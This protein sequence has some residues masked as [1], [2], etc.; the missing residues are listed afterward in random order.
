[1]RVLIFLIGLLLCESYAADKTPEFVTE[2]VP[3]WVE[4]VKEEEL[5]NITDQESASGVYY[6]LVDSQIK[7]ET[8]KIEY[9]THI[10]KKVIN[11]NGI[12][13][14]ALLEIE[15]DPLCE[16]ISLHHV[17]VKRGKDVINHL[18]DAKIKVLQR[19]REL[20]RKNYS[21]RKSISIILDDIRVG[22]IISY[23]FTLK[24]TNINDNKSFYIKVYLSNSVPIRS[25]SKR[26][27]WPQSLPPLAI[28]NHSTDF[29]VNIKKQGKYI[30]Y[31]WQKKDVPVY[32]DEPYTPVWHDVE[33]WIEISTNLN[34]HDI[35]LALSEHYKV[36]DLP[37][38]IKKHVDRIIS[39]EKNLGKR[40]IT[41]MHFIQDEIRYM[42]MSDRIDGYKPLNAEL[43]YE[44]R[45]GDCKDKTYLALTMLKALGIEVHP[46]VVHTT[47]GKLLDSRLANPAIFNHIIVVAI[48][49][50]KKYWIDPTCSFQGGT[51]KNY[52]QPDYGYAL[53]LD[54]RSKNLVKMPSLELAEPSIEFYEKFDLS[55]GP[56]NPNYLSIKTVYK[57]MHADSQREYFHI[58]PKK[59]MNEF[60]LQYLQ[61]NYPSIRQKS[62]VI[63]LDDREKNV[64]IVAEDYEIPD[65]WKR[66]EA[67]KLWIMY[68]YVDEFITYLNNKNIFADRKTPVSNIFPRYITKKIEM[69][70]HDK[71]DF[72]TESIAVT[73][74][75]FEF[76]KETQLQDL[77]YSI[78]YVY[79]SLSDQVEHK[80]IASYI[81]NTD[82]AYALLK[83]N[84]CQFDPSPP[85]KITEKK[86]SL[87]WPIFLLLV[88]ALIF[89][90]FLAKKIYISKPKVLLEKDESSKLYGIEGWPLL[91]GF[92]IIIN[93]IVYF[94]VFYST[95]SMVLSHDTWIRLSTSSA[96][97]SFLL[98]LIFEETFV[99]LGLVALWGLTAILFLKKKHL[100]PHV[101]VFALFGD[102]LF[103]ISD[104]VLSYFFLSSVSTKTNITTSIILG[105]IVLIWSVYMAKS[106][107]IRVTFGQNFSFNF[108][109][110]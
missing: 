8:Y 83:S 58:T 70:L 3:S 64:V 60:Y 28:K 88:I 26:I 41:V 18:K 43:T 74:P 29:Q 72:K 47:F 42:G 33:P 102:F 63:I 30:E 68:T 97:K 23:S 6:Q 110:K 39:A 9:F 103:I 37:P 109:N 81:K 40:F 90:I 87:N 105:L 2:D 51:L 22:D 15:Y 25:M 32:Q 98:P 101:F 106:K 57:S 77:N 85:H 17:T 35:N 44:R 82:Q 80:M 59:E 20:E 67:K 7:K 89:F 53:I 66:R 76:K 34:W 99:S 21:G 69:I 38:S 75:T 95:A 100:F 84:L 10:S 16:S 14:A 19:E 5:S 55:K 61:K 12:D 91:S 86:D 56:E 96:F 65:L 108:K 94:G 1:M 45:F 31:L 54:G 73:D 92:Y 24:S 4:L 62:E 27:L 48:I 79:R 11:Q 50:G 52:V 13:N 104:Q 71:W 46:A 78:S 49:N 36:Q 93:I 107:R